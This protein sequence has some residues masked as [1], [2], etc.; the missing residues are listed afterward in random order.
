M[1]IAPNP[2]Y[3]FRNQYVV[4]LTKNSCF[5]VHMLAI[6]IFWILLTSFFKSNDRSSILANNYDI[7]HIF[8]CCH[9]ARRKLDPQTKLY[10][11]TTKL[12]SCE[13]RSNLSFSDPSYSLPPR[14]HL[15]CVFL[16]MCDSLLSIIIVGTYS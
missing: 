8:L 16:L 4:F 1:I 14:F 6:S 5:G 15:Y 12:L 13:L 9:I 2:L 7:L 3:P 11:T 10:K